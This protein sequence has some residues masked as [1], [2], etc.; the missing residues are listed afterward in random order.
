MKFNSKILSLKTLSFQKNK[1]LILAFFSVLF[2]LI[3]GI[4]AYIVSTNSEINKVFEL[5]AVFN[6]DFSDKNNLEIFSGFVISGLPYVISMFIVGGSIFGKVLCLIFTSVKT[7]GLSII[8]SYLYC[9]A[10]LKGL[11]YALLVF[12]PGKTILIFSML[13]LT[14]ITMQMSQEIIYEDKKALSQKI[15]VYIFKFS[16]T[17]I[18]FLL[19]W[20]IDLFCHNLFSDLF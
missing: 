20:I 16:V 7:M 19:S 11:E 15:K 10:G 17:F 12:F 6:T 2:G 5:F 13:F 18:L 4:V 9:N 1:N 8:T 14:V 3:L